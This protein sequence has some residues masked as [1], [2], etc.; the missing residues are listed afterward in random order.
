MK[1]SF[2]FWIDLIIWNSN[3]KECDSHKIYLQ[4]HK[5]SLEIKCFLTIFFLTFKTYIKKQM[6]VNAKGLFMAP[7]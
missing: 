4:A 3:G 2:Y 5:V 6:Y 1:P 7:V